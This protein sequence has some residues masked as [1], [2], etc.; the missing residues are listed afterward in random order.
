MGSYG[1]WNAR[2]PEEVQR[3]NGKRT[4]FNTAVERYESIK[5]LQGKRKALDIRPLG[6][7]ERAWER[8]VKVSDTEY[9]LTCFGWSYYD[10]EKLLG[11]PKEAVK[12]R[13]A[14]TLKQEGNVETIT[15]H[16]NRYGFVSPSIY[17]FYAFNLPLGLNMTKN[18]AR[19]YISVS[20]EDGTHGYYTMEKGDIT[21]YRPKGSVYWTP[22]QVHRETVHKLDRTKTK[23]IRK[24]LSN[25]VNYATMMAPLV[26]PKYKW[27]AILGTNWKE[28]V[29]QPNPEE[30]PELWIDCVVA[31]AS[32]VS[33]YNWQTRTSEVNQKAIP[34]AIYREVYRAEKPFVTEVVELGEMCY[35]RYRSWL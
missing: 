6:E 2:S 9:Y 7:R 5:P 1:N 21:L 11:N 3:Y 22:L 17:Y 26:E 28:V 16:G 35:D 18:K 13:R 24:Q 32:K 34:D 19:T 15:I 33:R 12:E 8:V 10:K 14:I 23:E 25:F 30:Y 27:G 29:A 31:I 4:D 20:N